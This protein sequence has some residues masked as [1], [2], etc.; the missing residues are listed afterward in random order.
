MGTIYN[1]FKPGTKS[2]PAAPPPRSVLNEGQTTLGAYQT[3]LPQQFDL[4]D[5][6]ATR[7][8]ALL[9]KFGPS[10]TAATRATTLS[11]AGA[12]LLSELNKQAN[13]DLAA[14]STLTPSMRRELEQYTRA[15]QASRG[16]GFSP[17]DLTE[18]VMTLGTAGQQLQAQR[19]AFAQSVLQQDYQDPSG[20]LA[21]KTLLGYA[22]SGQDFSVFNPYAQDVYDTNFNAQW[23]DKI[24]TRNYNAA[25]KAA[26]INAIGQ[27][28]SS[29]VSSASK[30]GACWVA[31]L[32]FG[33][34]NCFWLL[35][36]GWIGGPA[37]G[38]LR[39]LYLARGERF[40]AWLKSRPRCTAAVG[41]LMRWI[42]VRHY[43]Q[44]NC[45]A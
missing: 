6:A 19:R 14:G 5:A 33:E 44:W 32:V 28:D 21:L 17:N 39:R 13:S 41:W 30:A 42:V 1:F 16:F 37:P 31:R 7:S 27:L 9:D 43:A 12:D 29:I 23:T 2:E 4:A 8:A 20:Q 34:D 15:G 10:F 45:H 36:R 35:F 40:A 38:W 22:P 26:V 11:P 18:E 25:I 3:L 24:A